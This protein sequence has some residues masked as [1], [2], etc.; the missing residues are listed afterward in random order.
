M[1]V[2]EIFESIQGESTYSGL[3][4]FFVRLAGC[5]LRCTYCDTIYAYEGGEELGIEDIIDRAER[6]RLGLVCI[7]GGEPLL[8][9]DVFSLVPGLIDRGFT[10]LV[11]TNGSMSISGMDRRAVMIMDMKTPKSGMSD[12]M[13]LGNLKLLKRSDQLKFVIADRGDYIWA[14]D[15]VVGRD[16]QD[17]CTVL[18]S[19]AFGL[20]DPRDLV[21]WILEDRLRVRL[22]LQLH[23]YIFGPH[24]RG[25]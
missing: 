25:V 4:C 9:T 16:L 2:C 19:P 22:N 8:Q 11:E 6:S 24:E 15:M 21:R 13:D 12:R 23:K 18:L 3:P 20:L 7:T 1:I 17:L 5:N 10:V 14:R